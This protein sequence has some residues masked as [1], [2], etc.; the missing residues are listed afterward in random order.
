MTST[1]GHENAF[2]SFSSASSFES[3]SQQAAAVEHLA[4]SLRFLVVAAE[5]VAPATFATGSN[6]TRD[7]LAVLE[8]AKRAALAEASAAVRS[9]SRA[10]RDDSRALLQ[11]LGLHSSIRGTGSGGEGG[12]EDAET[13]RAVYPGRRGLAP[14]SALSRA[15][16]SLAVLA[17]AITLLREFLTLNLLPQSP[18]PLFTFSRTPVISCKAKRKRMSSAM[19]TRRLRASAPRA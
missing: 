1:P 15:R 9:V 5:V 13:A 12:S 18:G 3:A 4:A 19:P 8:R 7:T 17:H 6:N 2:S 11:A 10:L 16:A 14:G